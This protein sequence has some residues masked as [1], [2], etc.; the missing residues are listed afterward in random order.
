MVELPGKP[1]FELSTGA[2]I[3]NL[4]D[5]PDLVISLSLASGEL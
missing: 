3:M 5:V 4:R 1:P 2:P